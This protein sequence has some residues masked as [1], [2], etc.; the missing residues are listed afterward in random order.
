MVEYATSSRVDM[1]LAPA[2]ASQYLS[3]SSKLEIVNFYFNY[4]DCI[5]YFEVGSI[6]SRINAGTP[7]LFAYFQCYKS[8]VWGIIFATILTLSI[9]SSLNYLSIYQICQ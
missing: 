8:G 6:L 2:T 1:L 9:V 4:T 3:Y 7:T 5:D